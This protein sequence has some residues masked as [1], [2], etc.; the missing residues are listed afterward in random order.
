MFKKITILLVPFMMLT[1]SAVH[2]RGTKAFKQRKIVTNSTRFAVPTASVLIRRGTKPF[3]HANS[4]RFVYP[5]QKVNS[6]RLVP[7]K[8]RRNAKQGLRRRISVG[9]L[10]K[11]LYAL[12]G[13]RSRARRTGGKSICDQYRALLI[14]ISDLMVE[15]FLHKPPRIREAAV[16]SALFDRAQSDARRHGCSVGKLSPKLKGLVI[17]KF[18]AKK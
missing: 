15:A 18:K 4:T 9:E 3:K 1:V 16:L 11:R 14:E 10:R 2:G 6:K 12:N 17:N 7:M 13:Q 8:I 5:N